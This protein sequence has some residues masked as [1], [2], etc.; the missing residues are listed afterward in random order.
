MDMWLCMKRDI[1]SAERAK[2]AYEDG[3]AKVAEVGKAF[4][5]HAH[6]LKDKQAA[7]R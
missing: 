6:L 7:E 1:S 2:E 3:S 5:D 4:Q